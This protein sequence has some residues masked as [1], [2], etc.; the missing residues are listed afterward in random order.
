LR[1]SILLAT[2]ITSERICTPLTRHKAPPD[3]TNYPRRID[4]D[5]VV[6]DR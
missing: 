5:H 4:C 6:G 1:G 2:P 3:K